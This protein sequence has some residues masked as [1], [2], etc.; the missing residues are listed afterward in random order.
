VARYSKRN[1]LAKLAYKQKGR[2]YYCEQ[3]MIVGGIGPRAATRD[4]V[5]SR[6]HGGKTH[7]NVVAA[8][9]RCNSHKGTMTEHE[10]KSQFAPAGWVHTD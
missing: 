3:Q 1:S 4:H 7:R 10:F 2:C 9:R 8:C 6:A 5:V